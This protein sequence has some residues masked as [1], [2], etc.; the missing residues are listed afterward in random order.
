MKVDVTV[1]ARCGKKHLG[2]T[3]KRLTNSLGMW[4]ATCPVKKEP[5]ILEVDR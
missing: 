2:M 4:W 3:F 5:I 1:C